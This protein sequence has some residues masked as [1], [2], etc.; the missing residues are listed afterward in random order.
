MNVRR[1]DRYEHIIDNDL[2]WNSY[3]MLLVAVSAEYKM[4]NEQLKM[5]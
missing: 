2:R 1:K 5:L 3:V 4:P